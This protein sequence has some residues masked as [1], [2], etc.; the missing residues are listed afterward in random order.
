MHDISRNAFEHRSTASRVA[1]Y[2]RR[3]IADGVLKPGDRIIELEVAA[4][5]K[6]SRSPIREALLLL[7][8][9]GLV[10][11]LA[12]HGAIVSRLTKERFEQLLRFRLMLEDFAIT[13]AANNADDDDIRTFRKHIALIRQA[14]KNGNPLECVEADLYAHKYLIGL[15]KNVFLEQSYMATISLMRM[16]IR[17]ACMYYERAE[18]LADEHDQF[19]NALLAHDTE[20]ARIV[21]REH[22]EHGFEEACSALDA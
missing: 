16:Y 10:T 7:S 15:A 13:C 4:A 12:Y 6:V 1:E 11:I 5:L 19:V 22:I 17:M 9:E 21:M 3:R 2:L 14:S 18:E 8:Q 20:R